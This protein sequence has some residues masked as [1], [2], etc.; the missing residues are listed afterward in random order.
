[1]LVLRHKTE[2]RGG[3]GLRLRRS[4][5]PRQQKRQVH[6]EGCGPS[7]A[8]WFQLPPEEERLSSDAWLT[9]S[10]REDPG[11]VTIDPVTWQVRASTWELGGATNIHLLTP[12]IVMTWE[13]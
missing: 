3:D 2:A 13:M 11:L 10:H 9:L 12:L 1:M 4:P 7:P 8:H 6:T 5:C